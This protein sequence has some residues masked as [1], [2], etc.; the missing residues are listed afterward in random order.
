MAD[1]QK[2]GSDTLK[3]QRKVGLSGLRSSQYVRKKYTLKKGVGHIH[4]TGS[5]VEVGGRMTAEEAAD[6]NKGKNQ[7]KHKAHN[8]LSFAKKDHSREKRAAYI[9]ENI[10]NDLAA[11]YE[12]KSVRKAD[13]DGSV[14]AEKDADKANRMKKAAYIKEKLQRDIAAEKAASF[15]KSDDIPDNFQSPPGTETN[16]TAQDEKN[17]VSF[18]SR[19]L[20]NLEH[21]SENKYKSSLDSAEVKQAY[22]AKILEAQM[23]RHRPMLSLFPQKKQKCRLLKMPRRRSLPVIML[24]RVLKWR[25]D[26]FPLSKT[27]MRSV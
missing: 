2:K 26:I 15:S 19:F 17:E 21:I 18:E 20:G 7:K 25:R 14:S 6:R 16:G 24:F 8:A 23:N 22:K 3:S 10:Q 11:S 5:Y 1:K 12:E 9:K 4:K 13:T 27:A